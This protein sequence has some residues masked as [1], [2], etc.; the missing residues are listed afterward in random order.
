MELL[1]TKGYIPNQMKI[2]I[3]RPYRVEKFQGTDCIVGPGTNWLWIAPTTFEAMICL[4]GAYAEGFKAAIRAT[5]P[6][7]RGKR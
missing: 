3:K 4:N 2:T 6:S 5:K 7:R 1:D